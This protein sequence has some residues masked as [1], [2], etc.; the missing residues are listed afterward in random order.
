MADPG[1]GGRVLAAEIGAGR[2][3]GCVGPDLAAALRRRSRARP[4]AEGWPGSRGSL[5]LQQGET[6]RA[7]ALVDCG[8]AS[9]LAAAPRSRY[10]FSTATSGPRWR[11][12]R[13]ADGQALR[14]LRAGLADLHEWQSSFGSLDLQTGVAGHGSAARP[15]AGWRSR[16][17]RARPSVLFEWSE[18][19][20]MLASRVQPV[21][22]PED[23]S[24]VADLTELR[25]MAAE[26]GRR[27]PERE[28]ELRQRV[29][30]R[31]W[32]HRGSGE[33]VDPVTL[34]EL[35]AR[36][37]RR[38][39]AGRVRRDRRVPRSR[40]V[41]TTDAHDV[42]RPRTSRGRW[43]ACSVGCC[44]T[45][46]SRRR[47]CRTRWVGSCGRS[48][49]AGSTPSPSSWWRRCSTRS[50]SDASYS[51]RPAC[52]PGCRGR[53]CPGS[54]VARSRSPSRRPRGWPV[55]RRRCGR[56]RPGSSPARGSLR[57]EDEV[58]A[59]AKEWPGARVLT[60]ESASAA[61]VCE[62]AETV[63]VLHVAAHGRHSAENPLF[64]GLQLADGPWFGYDIDRLRQAPGRRAAVGVRGRAARTCAGARSCSA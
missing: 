27:D 47:T 31:A 52:W 29:R 30:E 1:R 34:A 21:R 10:A 41:V 12:A 23:E 60:G 26:G 7:A 58:T 33:V 43:T 61:A 57:A 19:A 54:P 36:A 35:T 38:D 8:P 15:R 48:W 18:R 14:H 24:I 4:A 11:L 40:L 50:V 42:G 37:G 6:E 49:P 25:E 56:R 44:P 62:L 28:A 20:R 55:V 39:R 17:S 59:A 13:G 2:R 16:S 9:G 63:D 32:Q 64:S 46:M 51:P 3:A 22:A 5:R 53:C 45:S